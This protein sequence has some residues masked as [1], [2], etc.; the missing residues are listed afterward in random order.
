[1]ASSKGCQTSVC[2]QSLKDQHSEVQGQSRG[3]IGMDLAKMPFPYQTTA[4]PQ[5]EQCQPQSDLFVAWNRPGRPTY[6]ALWGQAWAWCRGRPRGAGLSGGR[7]RRTWH[8]GRRK[9]R[10]DRPAAAQQTARP[11]HHCGRGPSRVY[12]SLCRCLSSG[13]A[14]PTVV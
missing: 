1:M 10:P 7:R 6:R 5:M 4:N 12:I 3:V 11:R 13:H 9:R 8:S 14:S 2:P